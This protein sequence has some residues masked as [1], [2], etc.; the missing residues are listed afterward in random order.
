[1][2]CAIESLS[3]KYSFL[4]LD[5]RINFWQMI[6]VALNRSTNKILLKKRETHIYI[7]ES[8]YLS[9]VTLSWTSSDHLSYSSIP[10]ELNYSWWKYNPRY[11]LFLP[12]ILTYFCTFN[13]VWLAIFY[14]ILMFDEHFNTGSA[15]WIFNITCFTSV[16]VYNKSI[17]YS[18]RFQKR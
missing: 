7:I 10:E 16:L 14:V 12:P 1:M 13:N 5:G 3:S 9:F 18:L 17:T 15:A 8:I 11:V 6:D 4:T 2:K